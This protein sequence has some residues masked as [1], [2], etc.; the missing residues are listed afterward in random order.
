[1]SSTPTRAQVSAG[2]AAFRRHNGRVE[3]VLI[4]VGEKPRWQLPKGLVGKNET[5]EEAALREVREE[6]GV[7]TELIELIETIEYWYYGGGA[8]KVRFHKYVHLYLLRYLSGNVEDH[9]HEVHEACWVEIDTAVEQLAFK[10]E[11]QVVQKAKEM[12]RALQN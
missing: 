8:K 12:V 6:G 5:P 9:D 11:K 4:S 10:S 3:V 7:E 1:M 2:G